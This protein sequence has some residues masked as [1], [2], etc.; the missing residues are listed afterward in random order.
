MTT[1]SNQLSN[2]FKTGLI[3]LQE[4]Q[5]V[6]IYNSIAKEVEDLKFCLKVIKSEAQDRANKLNTPIKPSSTE[7]QAPVKVKRKSGRPR[8]T[9]TV[10]KV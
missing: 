5:L 7:C 2:I 8:K 3:N 10:S 6:N 9:D 1:L 4:E